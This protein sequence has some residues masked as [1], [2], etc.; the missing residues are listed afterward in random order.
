MITHSHELVEEMEKRVITM[1]RGTI[2]DEKG[3]YITPEAA[4]LL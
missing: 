1:D 3:G 4:L 2:S